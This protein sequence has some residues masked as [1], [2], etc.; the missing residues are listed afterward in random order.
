MSA[1]LT[2]SSAG[3][4]ACSSQLEQLIR[5]EMEEDTSSSSEKAS[6]D[7]ED[8]NAPSS[9]DGKD[10]RS[11]SAGASENQV[12]DW[13]AEVESDGNQGT[14]TDG[15]DDFLEDSCVDMISS[16]Y[17]TVHQFYG[18]D[19]ASAG[20]DKPDPT[21]G[22]AAWSDFE[23]QADY[24]SDL[25]DELRDYDYDAL[26]AEQQEKYTI[27]ERYLEN[28]YVMDSHPY[29]QMLF[30]GSGDEISNIINC[31]GNFVFY[32][33]EDFEDY[34]KL[35]DSVPDYLSDVVEI[36]QKQ[37]DAG[38][39]ITDA[40]LDNVCSEIKTYCDAGEKCSTILHFESAADAFD[41]L[42][43]D[44]RKDLKNKLTDAVIN[45]IIPAF[46]DTE[47]ALNSMQGSRDGDDTLCS[48]KDGA[49]YYQVMVRDIL[50]Y[51]ADLTEVASVLQNA[52][53]DISVQLYDLIQNMDE[54]EM[55]EEPDLAD[56]QEIMDYLKKHMEDYPSGP[57][58]N[59]TFSY[60][61]GDQESGNVVAYYLMPTLT[62]PTDNNI[63]R[64]SNSVDDKLT[65]YTSLAHEGMPGHMYQYTKDL[66][67][68][69][70][71][72]FIMT[73]CLGFAE[74]WAQY[75][76]YQALLAAPMS[77]EAC[78]YQALLDE[79]NYAMLALA[80]VEFNGLGMSTDDLALQ[81]QQAGYTDEYAS[82][83]AEDL[84]DSVTMGAG[85]FLAY[86]YGMVTMLNLREEAESQ[87]G[88]GFDV[89][90][91]HEVVLGGGN[92]PLDILQDHAESWIREQKYSQV[93]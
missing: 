4:T 30:S 71:M 17:T 34:I 26:T 86:G 60:L 89:T 52:L 70:S 91:W 78:Q 68:D 44:D 27:F 15:F 49:A 85:S 12:S 9:D 46:Q 66:A 54:S 90:A 35:A 76:E 53:E 25:L 39:F 38:Y 29:F 56:A 31:L 24:Y 22:T 80:D 45:G 77:S 63:I 20:L 19:Y 82:S 74:G 51:D 32:S 59:C 92:V 1:V 28:N 75:A 33:E 16:S 7:G 10:R 37:A 40:E 58:V 11:S 13:Y 64:I 62:D 65:L 2:A 87:L 18:D 55:S 84:Y 43:D 23:D 8:S 81:I 6:G 3:M 36:T 5:E 69:P 79:L 83:V 50:G 48:L 61:E 67:E 47:D 42:S 93:A 14:K 73:D 41:G 57:D 88:A 21:F 72:Y